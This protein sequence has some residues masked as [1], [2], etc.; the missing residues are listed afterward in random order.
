MHNPGA[1]GHYLKFGSVF[2]SSLSMTWSFAHGCSEGVIIRKH[3]RIAL[4]GSLT[5]FGVL[6]S[7]YSFKNMFKAF[8]FRV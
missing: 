3:F 6:V 4:L 7:N 8:K 5:I 2:M 1:A